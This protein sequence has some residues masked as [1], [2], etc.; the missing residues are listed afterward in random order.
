MSNYKP[1][2]QPHYYATT[3][4]RVLHHHYHQ[5]HQ[6]HQNYQLDYGHFNENRNIN[7][8]R[9]DEKSCYYD[10][11]AFSKSKLWSGKVESENSKESEELYLKHIQRKPLNIS[12]QK[13]TT[14]P[15]TCNRDNFLDDPV[16]EE[17]CSAR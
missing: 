13:I 2:Y 8:R 10:G 17:I 14:L 9:N 12:F 4:R 11:K 5:Q 15:G 6:G 3:S 1:Y 16:Y 7:L